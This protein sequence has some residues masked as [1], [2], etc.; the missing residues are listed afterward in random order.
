MA[1]VQNCELQGRVIRPDD[2]DYPGKL[3]NKRY[4][5]TLQPALINVVDNVEHVR[6]ALCYAKKN[7]LRVRVR[8]GGHNYEAFCFV[9]KGL[10]IDV[11]NL[12]DFAIDGDTCTFGA[13]W[14]QKPLYARLAANDLY[15]AGGICDDVAGIPVYLGGGTGIYHRAHGMA[16][17][18]LLSVTLIDH[19]GR[20]IVCNE[21]ENDRL[22]WACKGAG[23]GN[24]GVAVSATVRTF[25]RTDV[26]NVKLEWDWDERVLVNWQA[27]LETASPR[28]ANI[29]L[30][31]GTYEERGAPKVIV[32]TGLFLGT[33]AECDAALKSLTEREPKPRQVL[34]L[35]ESAEEAG[36]LAR[37]D[38]PLDPERAWSAERDLLSKSASARWKSTGLLATDALSRDGVVELY[39]FMKDA[40]STLKGFSIAFVGLGGMIDV[41][42]PR[43]TAYPHRKARFM[44]RIVANWPHASHDTA[45]LTYHRLVK[46]AL[47]RRTASKG[48]Y[49]NYS[50]LEIDN[51]M[52]AYFGANAAELR[53]VKARY[54]PNNFFVYPQSIR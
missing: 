5:D 14:L 34:Y 47:A 25:K 41:V 22:F 31:L 7:D 27:W 50:D 16:C 43:A 1:S 28:F 11:S 6:S 54:D 33:Q 17:D 13:G 40:P 24:F 51:Y 26:C 29:V 39:R 37:G 2:E 48:Y 52:T 49:F 53:L 38:S 23:N 42:E 10:V 32:C 15:I 21:K 8:S 36:Q 44:F 35:E 4:L 18:T 46:N 30:S 45:N 12:T 3:W 9:D 19:D 20:T